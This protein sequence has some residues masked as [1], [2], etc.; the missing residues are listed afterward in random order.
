M[1]PNYRE[2]QGQPLQSH[3][4]KGLVVL[5]VAVV[6]IAA[7]VG[8][9]ALAGGAPNHKGRCVTVSAAGP[10]GGGQLQECGSAARSWCQ[11]ESTATGTLAV[12]IRA[13]CRH[14]GFLSA[15]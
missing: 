4:R 12:E 3:E 11:T 15:K 7:A 1:P 6:L 9:W 2:Q 5:A 10:T 8:I 14:E 13:A